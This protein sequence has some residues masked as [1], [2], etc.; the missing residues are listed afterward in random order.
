MSFFRSHK[1]LTVVAWI[2]ALSLVITQGLFFFYTFMPISYWITYNSVTPLNEEV[3]VNDTIKFITSSNVYRPVG[4][5]FNDILYCRDR[6]TN[7]YERYNEQ[8]TSRG[9][10]VPGVSRLTVWPFNPG[11]AYPTTCY[12]ESTITLRLPLH[13]NRPFRYDGLEEGKEFKVKECE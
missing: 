12:L 4:L 7:K 13:V 2:I 9:L 5:K 10:A 11:V 8:N 1:A 6:D 3:C